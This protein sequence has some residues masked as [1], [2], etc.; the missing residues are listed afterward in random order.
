MGHVDTA[1][2]LMQAAREG[3]LAPSAPSILSS[4]PSPVS[5]ATTPSYTDLH[6]LVLHYEQAIPAAFTVRFVGLGA[7]RPLVMKHLVEVLFVCCCTLKITHCTF[8]NMS[9]GYGFDV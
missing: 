1:A 3:A 7:L 4:S 2:F 6:E 9:T 5:S 8:L